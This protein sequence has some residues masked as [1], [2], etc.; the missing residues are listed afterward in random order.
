MNTPVNKISQK[1]YQG[2]NSSILIE[3]M[4]SNNFNSNEWLT[5]KQ[6]NSLNLKIIKGSKGTRIYFVKGTRKNKDGE[7]ESVFKGYSVFNL[8]QCTESDSA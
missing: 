7:S 8:E 3:S 6:A 2:K 4:S 5:M 1:E